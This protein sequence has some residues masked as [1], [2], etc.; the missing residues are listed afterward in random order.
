M[1]IEST[2]QQRQQHI[3]CLRGT[4]NNF[5]LCKCGKRCWFWFCDYTDKWELLDCTSCKYDEDNN[6][7]W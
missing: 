1:T 4:Q 3:E 6:D 5:C 7:L 2:E